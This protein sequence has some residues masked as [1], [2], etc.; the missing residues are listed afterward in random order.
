MADSLD[1]RLDQINSKLDDIQT[2]L[3]EIRT[4]VFGAAG[5]GG[6]HRWVADINRR[7]DGLNRSE[8]R[9]IGISVGASSAIGAAAW[10]VANMLK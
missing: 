8:A 9:I 6:L 2:E 3:T 1:K 5:Q 4:T 7:V 10:L